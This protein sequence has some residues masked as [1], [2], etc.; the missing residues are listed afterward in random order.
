M[1]CYRSIQGVFTADNARRR[2]ANLSGSTTENLAKFIV[3]KYY[4]VDLNDKPT[5]GYISRLLD[6]SPYVVV[7][8]TGM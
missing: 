3:K 1:F 5:L 2:L 7:V 8:K 6:I 4:K